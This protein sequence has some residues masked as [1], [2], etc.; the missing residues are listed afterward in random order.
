M[1]FL[2][3]PLRYLRFGQPVCLLAC[4]PAL[5]VPARAC[6]LLLYVV[7]TLAADYLLSNKTGTMQD[8]GVDD[9]AK[10]RLDHCQLVVHG[11]EA[12]RSA[13]R[14]LS[15]HLT[16]YERPYVQRACTG[17][18]ETIELSQDSCKHEVI[19]TALST[20]R[21]RGQP[22]NY[23]F[24][25]AEHKLHI[26]F[27]AGKHMKIQLESRCSSDLLYCGGEMRFVPAA[28]EQSTG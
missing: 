23:L 8:Y 25:P 3:H 15:P 26:G 1:R 21:N 28:G 24:N 5:R 9:D 10:D 13:P 12:A 18:K 27:P 20:L 11:E 17:N 6:V 22:A 7:E 19:T 14:Q 16:V 2:P 4:L